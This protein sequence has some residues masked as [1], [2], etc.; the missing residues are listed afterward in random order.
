[1]RI[2]WIWILVLVLAVANALDVKS[3][4]DNILEEFVMD[5]M[6]KKLPNPR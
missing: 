4:R 2:V 6:P 3:I 1:M 5:F